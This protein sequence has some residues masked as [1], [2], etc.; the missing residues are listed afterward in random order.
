MAYPYTLANK[1]IPD[2]T[3]VQANFDYVLGLVSGGQAIKS[4]TLANLKTSAAAAPTV[5]FLA[6]PTDLDALVLYC[7]KAD[8]GPNADGFITI[9]SFEAIV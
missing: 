5:A 3:K 9:V 6:I 2:A 7:G 4:D 1:T 8:R